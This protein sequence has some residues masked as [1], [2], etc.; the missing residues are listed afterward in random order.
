MSTPTPSNPAQPNSA[1]KK[2]TGHVTTPSHL[3]LSSPAPRSIPSPAATRKDQAGKT[4]T[5]HPTASSH[6]SKT[7]GGTPMMPNLSQTGNTSNS[8]PGAHN[9]S[10]GTPS[11]LAGLGVDMGSGTPG[12]MNMSTPAGASSMMPSM[13]ELGFTTGGKRN[14]DEERRAKMRKVL[15]SIGRSKG[16]VSEESIARIS[17][18]VGF[19]TTIDRETLSPE[20]K[21]RL[22]GNRDFSVAG[23]HV[24]IDVF[25]ENHVVKKTNLEVK[26]V[27][28]EHQRAASEVLLQDLIPS[29]GILLHSTL[30]RF[31]T[32]LDSLARLDRLSKDVNCFEALSK[33]HKSLGRLYEL[34][35]RTALETE[36]DQQRAEREVLCKKSGKPVIHQNRRIGLALE[37]WTNGVGSTKTKQDNSRM[38]ID[39]EAKLD[40]ADEGLT[41]VYALHIEVEGS[42]AAL[43]PALRV[44]DEWLPETFELPSSESVQ[45][46]PW[47]EPQPTYISESSGDHSSSMAIDN[48]QRLPDLRFIAKLDPPVVMPYADASRILAVVGLE[49]P[50]YFVANQYHLML[51]NHAVKQLQQ[52]I[53]AARSVLSIQ[54]DTEEEVLHKYTL[55]V[56][57]PDYGF[58]LETMPFSHP[59]QLVEVLPTLRQW[60]SF[61]ALVRNTFGENPSALKAPNAANG[62]NG[63]QANGFASDSKYDAM[64]LD[65]VLES[66]REDTAT[67]QEALA[68]NVGLT[69]VPQP[70][71]SFS[72]TDFAAEGVSSATVQVLPNADI[73][74]TDYSDVSEEEAAGNEERGAHTEQAKKRAKALAVCADPGVWIEWMRS[75]Q[76]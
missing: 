11:A 32:N 33:L 61:G 47:Q 39:G 65:E 58:R 1:S 73:I 46:I 18:R 22:V 26:D 16:R 70:T 20:E 68:V 41:D 21:E 25:M 74:V 49:P 5:N 13:S 19:A 15:K 64:S 30:D 55:D 2:A 10:F 44:S 31:A 17:R 28:E 43:Y 35:I 59:R 54:G 57:K 4:P 38:E 37:Y 67:K 48:A 60:A 36:K 50:Q 40:A 75:N 72:Y 51:L 24:V 56:S 6:G 9:V 71:L 34:E 27:L 8:S 62:L 23:N 66:G 53:E 14:E 3:G 29:D 69:T 76:K 12:L 52:D 63:M 45:G 7:L 42:A